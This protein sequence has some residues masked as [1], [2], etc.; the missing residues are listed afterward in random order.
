MQHGLTSGRCWKAVMLLSNTV[1]QDLGPSNGNGT[2]ERIFRHVSAQDT[3]MRPS[4]LLWMINLSSKMRP[5]GPDFEEKVAES[6]LG[7]IRDSL[8]CCS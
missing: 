8:N 3:Y 5:K 1:S 2:Q 7:D 4:L 6:H